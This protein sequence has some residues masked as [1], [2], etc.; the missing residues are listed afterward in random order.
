MR[1]CPQDKAPYRGCP[2]A[3]L[4][5][6]EWIPR[7]RAADR[8]AAENAARSVFPD[9]RFAERNAAPQAV[10]A[11]VR[12]EYF[13]V[14]YVESSHGNEPALGFDL[15]SDPVRREA[16][17]RA[18]CTRRRAGL[19]IPPAV[20]RASGEPEARSIG[21][22]RAKS[23]N[24]FLDICEAPDVSEAQIASCSTLRAPASSPHC[25]PSR[26]GTTRC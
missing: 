24:A 18:E 12:E 5:A 1:C 16:L 4:Q 3:I 10:T 2:G 20:P 8:A 19:R 13:P 6:L 17:R 21:A 26:S 23:L 25:L 7:V 15:G 22:G 14:Y 9:C 11:V